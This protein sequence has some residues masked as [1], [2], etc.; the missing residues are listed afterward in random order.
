MK[1]DDVI[2]DMRDEGGCSEGGRVLW[3][4]DGVCVVVCGGVVALK[5][6]T[7]FNVINTDRDLFL[8]TSFKGVR[9]I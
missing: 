4:C 6:M 9:G 7:A 8:I 5:Q 1:G 2:G 3:W